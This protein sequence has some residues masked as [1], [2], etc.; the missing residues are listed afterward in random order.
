MRLVFVHLL[1]LT[2]LGCSVNEKKEN[3]RDYSVLTKIN[4]EEFK[5]E[6]YE[7]NVIIIN[8]WATWCK[9]CIAEFESLEKAKMKFKNK[10]VKIFAVSNE[11][12]SLI[13][14]F[15]K[16]R[17]F[18]LE[19]IK[20]HGDLSYFNAYSLPTTLVYDKSGIETFRLTGGVDFNTNNFINK[21]I[22]IEKL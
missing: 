18:N 20:L 10:K 9:P 13:K 16:K 6:S 14:D 17:K 3:D 2:I 7:G 19:F 15:V 12:I 4:G 22:E 1:F 11:D 21:I 8:I 5:L